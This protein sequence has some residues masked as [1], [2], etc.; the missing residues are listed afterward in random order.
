MVRWRIVTPRLPLVREWCEDL[1]GWRLA[2]GHARG[3]DL[4]RARAST[5]ETGH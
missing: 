4:I 5:R 3:L 2:R 1:T